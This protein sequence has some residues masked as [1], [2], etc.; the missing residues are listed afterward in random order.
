MIPRGPLLIVYTILCFQPIEPGLDLCLTLT[1]E[2]G[3][4]DL[5]LVL[6]QSLRQI[7]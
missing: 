2:F 6:G 3:R 4:K 5:V 1:R 7:W